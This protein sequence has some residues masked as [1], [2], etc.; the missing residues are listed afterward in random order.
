ML[1]NAERYVIN[2]N[3]DETPPSSNLHKLSDIIVPNHVINVFYKTFNKVDNKW[4][5]KNPAIA[6]KFFSLPYLT[7]AINHQDAALKQRKRTLKA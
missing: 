3:F 1:A 7:D 5:S 2:D 4:A 6:K